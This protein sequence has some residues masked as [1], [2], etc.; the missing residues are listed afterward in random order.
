M[1]HRP[2]F[3]RQ[4]IYCAE[5]AIAGGAMGC[6]WHTNIPLRP[7][8]ALCPARK[9]LERPTEDRSVF[10]SRNRMESYRD[11]RTRSK[12]KTVRASVEGFKIATRSYWAT[13]GKVPVL[14]DT[15]SRLN[16]CIG[17]LER[18]V[19][20]AVLQSCGKRLVKFLN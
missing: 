10:R 2:I 17:R 11:R 9:W 1:L 5:S 6:F 12:M 8:N 7:F 4:P 15:E 20:R 14:S 18:S 19:K 13:C 3:Q 16:C